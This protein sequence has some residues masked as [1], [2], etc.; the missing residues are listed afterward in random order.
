MYADITLD[1]S[2]LIRTMG[3]AKPN[4][5]FF[6]KKFQL[7][8]KSILELENLQIYLKFSPII[9]DSP[10]FESNLKENFTTYQYQ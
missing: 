6:R 5:T 8:T 7:F 3:N 10:K 2:L 4:P 9:Q 1:P